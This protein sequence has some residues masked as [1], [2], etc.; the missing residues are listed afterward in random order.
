[1]SM[2]DDSVLAHLVANRIGQDTKAPILTFEYEGEVEERTYA[3]LYANANK[4]AA[5][6]IDHGMEKGD[7]FGILLLNHPEVVEALVAAS[8]SG[9]VAVPIDPRTKG[10]K[11][12]YM[13]ND[14]GC[15]GIICEDYNL[16][17]VRQA[18][19]DS[20]DW[21]V[22]VGD[23]ASE[24]TIDYRALM[25]ADVE[26]IAV[27]TESGNDPLQILYTS[28]TT[29][30][31]KGIVK[32]NV[33][34]AQAQIL[35]SSVFGIQ[36]SDKLYT[37]LSLSHGNAQLMT[38]APALTMG[39]PVVFSRK[40]TRSR[41]WDITRQFRCTM[42]NLLG[43]MTAAIYSL[44]PAT[45]DGDNPIR[46]VISAGMPAAIWQDF[47]QRF[48]V[49][50][51]EVYGSAEG[52]L[53]WNAGNGPAGSFGNLRENPLFEGR[54]VDEADND[55]G[56]G[57]SGE[58]IWRFRSGE[59]IEVLYLNNP[60]ASAKKTRDGWFRTGDVVHADANGWLFFDYRKGGGIRHNGDF[61]NPAFVEK[62]IAES[63]LVDDVF[64]YGVPAA[65]G[66]PGEKDVVA[67]VVPR[68]GYSLDSDELFSV[69]R[70][71]L[72][73]NFV[74]TYVQVVDEIPK[75]ASEKPQERF[76]IEAFEKSPQRVFTEELSRV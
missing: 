8:I 9:C 18:A 23:N 48:D 6:F 52:G 15:R 72:E 10:A 39:V 47:A 44:P 26:N 35:G 63:G 57:Q 5:F 68:E 73:S 37:G 54:I 27:R 50:L 34:Y 36:D 71:G 14:S 11:L 24:P 16:E 2:Y 49:E 42:F 76:L 1:M 56:P 21:C 66:A 53:F 46:R 20:V 62:V 38:L 13:L 31:P 25:Q 65:S 17:A 64:V 12:A 28:G 43:G 67:A 33:N 51:L 60:E 30:D 55:C 59:A 32:P 74:P 4:L 7:R 3:E 40:F 70:E 61:I 69:C 41:L 45:N 29:G 75:T 58:L 19:L 22:Q